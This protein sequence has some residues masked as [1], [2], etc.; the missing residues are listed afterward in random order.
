MRHIRRR[1]ISL[2]AVAVV[3]IASLTGPA[4][5]RTERLAY[6]CEESPVAQT[7]TGRVWIEDGAL[8][9]RD[10]RY[11]YESVGDPLCDGSLTIEVNLNLDL[12]DWSGALWGTSFRELDAFD[13]GFV[14]SWNAHWTT[15]NPLAPDATDIWDGQYVGRGFG[16]LEGWQTRADLHEATHAL[17]VE[18]GFAFDPGA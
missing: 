18:E 8:H 16:E 9:V 7:S 4:W 11:L 2:I 3:A 6:Q 15:P 13:G 1:S 5:A 12:T 10:A 17:I 14:T